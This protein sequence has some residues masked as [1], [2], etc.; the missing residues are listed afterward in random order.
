MTSDGQAM[1]ARKPHGTRP[2]DR[3]L[4]LEE[5]GVFMLPVM[6]LRRRPDY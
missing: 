1:S 5:A 6:H 2:Y 4:F 3:R